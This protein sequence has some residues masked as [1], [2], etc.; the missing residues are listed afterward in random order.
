MC[1]VPSTASVLLAKLEAL[2]AVWFATLDAATCEGADL[3]QDVSASEFLGEGL[4]LSWQDDAALKVFLERGFAGA[5]IDEI[6]IVALSGKPTIYARF[7]KR[8]SSR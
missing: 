5:S 1:S 6:A 7:P 4:R 3:R 2:K 8:S